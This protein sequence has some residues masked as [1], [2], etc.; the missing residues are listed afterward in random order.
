MVPAFTQHEGE[1]KMHP[2]SKVKSL[3]VTAVLLAM[4]AG[5]QAALIEQDFAVSGDGLLILDTVTNRQWVDVS[6][7]TNVGGITGFFTSSIY[8]GQGFQLATA[9]DVSQFFTDA[10]AGNVLNGDNQIFTAN[11]HSAAQ[12]LY[13]LMEH[14]SPF[15]NMAGNPWIHG[16]I[17]FDGVTATIA[18]VGDGDFLSQ[19][20]GGSFDVGSNGSFWS[21]SDDV[22]GQVGIWAWRA[23][24]VPEP[25]SLALFGLG[26]AGLG[27]ARRRK[28]AA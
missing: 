23:A 9:A 21:L 13:S 11:N 24:A 19:P 18:R 6:H 25:A 26:L 4:S 27:F 3:A 7:S 15:S 14:A 16:F 1:L 20:G 12:S 22:G 10:G 2:L 28:N 5:A 8:A 17:F